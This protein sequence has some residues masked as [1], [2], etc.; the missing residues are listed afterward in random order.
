MYP[1]G[2][3]IYMRDRILGWFPY[4]N[5]FASPYLCK[6]AWGFMN[7]I[8]DHLKFVAWMFVWRLSSG[9]LTRRDQVGAKQGGLVWKR[10]Y[11]RVSISY[12]SRVKAIY[13]FLLK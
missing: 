9:L 7:P 1:L 6:D 3:F 4:Q 8:C 2:G 10:R 13:H 12:L 11:C 5:V